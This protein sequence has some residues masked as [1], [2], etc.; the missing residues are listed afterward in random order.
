MESIK[1]VIAT[2]IVGSMSML[3]A[4]AMVTN[5]NVVPAVSSLFATNKFANG[6][7]LFNDG[8]DEGRAMADI[9]NQDNG[10]I[11]C[12]YKMN[13]TELVEFRVAFA[14]MLVA[15][16]FNVAMLNNDFTIQQ[17]QNSPL[18]T[19]MRNALHKK[20]PCNK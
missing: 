5:Y 1:T 10:T 6:N 2:A 13:N 3:S 18:Q 8:T 11:Y 20:Y 17:L 15:E 4:V 16:S 9:F 7:E 19:L 14:G 12:V